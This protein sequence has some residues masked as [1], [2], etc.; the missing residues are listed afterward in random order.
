[1]VLTPAQSE[2]FKSGTLTKSNFSKLINTYEFENYLYRYCKI[3]NDFRNEY[4]G[5]FYRITNFSVFNYHI[6][7]TMKNGEC[8]KFN[9]TILKK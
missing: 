7:V 9:Y 4:L 5:D 3:V 2:Q 6:I 1:M 8:E